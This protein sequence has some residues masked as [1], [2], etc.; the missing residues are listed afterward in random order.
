MQSSFRQWAMP[1]APKPFLPPQGGEKWL[2]IFTFLF[3]MFRF[4]M[5]LLSLSLSLMFSFFMILGNHENYQY[6][7]F[8][9]FHFLC[10]FK[11]FFMMFRFSMLLLSLSLV[12]SFFMMFL[13]SR[14][15]LKNH[16]NYQ[17]VSIGLT[18]ICAWRGG[19][20]LESLC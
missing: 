16:K 13:G 11:F 19:D 6:V 9:H 12:F 10:I 1:R 18:F 4:S 2:C 5:L 3:M 7:S 17:Y 14:M 15:L 20:C 8:G